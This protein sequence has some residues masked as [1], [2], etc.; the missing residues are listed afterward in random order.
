MIVTVPKPPSVNQMYRYTA[1]G[2]FA[3]SYISTEGQKWFSV[4]GSITHK[5]F[6]K[7]KTL[8]DKLSLVAHLYTAKGQDVD[9]IGKA[10]CD[11]LQK[12]QLCLKHRCTHNLRIIKNDSLIYDLRIIKHVVHHLSEEKLIFSLEVLQEELESPSLIEQ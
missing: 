9:N 2:G 8:E 11:M 1:R 12:C 5:V 7:Q 3:R 4:A 6:G 10:L